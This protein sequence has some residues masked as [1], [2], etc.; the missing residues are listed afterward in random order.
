M[1]TDAVSVGPVGSWRGYLCPA[2]EQ[3]FLLPVC[4][5]EW[6]DGDHLAWWV[7][8]A[9]E[10]M[11]TSALHARSGG[12]V[13]RRPYLPEMLLALVLYGYLTGV[14]SSRR[15]EAGCRT[16]AALRVICGGLEP[17]HATIARFVVAHERA[18][19]GLFVEGL[20][21]CEQAGLV[22]LSVVALDGTKMGA[23]A[24][25]AR[26]RDAGWI[27]REV[28]KLMALTAAE[29]A[30]P[31]ASPPAMARGRAGR[32]AR[33]EAALA[34]IEAAEEAESV[35]ARERARAARARR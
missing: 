23:D 35:Q 17:D 21:L 12:V 33:L 34:V 32:L 29:D 19:A 15:L 30:R 28:T 6:L 13:G 3:V 4:M 22:D 2:R 31:A 5:R 26:N 16:D 14:R 9:V 11:D 27:G 24:S 1:V 20:R 18:L 25:L 10:L 8:D 7:L